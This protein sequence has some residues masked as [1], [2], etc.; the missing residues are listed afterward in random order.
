MVILVHQ[1][2]RPSW[3][4]LACGQAW[5]CDPAREELVTALGPVPLAMYAWLTLE[6]AAGDLPTTPGAELFERFL[7]RT[8]HT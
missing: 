8:R 3:D 7:K 5:P 4:C 2:E 1:P 6:Q